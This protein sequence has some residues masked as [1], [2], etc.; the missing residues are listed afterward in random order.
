MPIF[1]RDST[2]S[3][4]S[5]RSAERHDQA[6]GI[7]GLF[8]NRSSHSSYSSVAASSTSGGKHHS[9][10]HRT[11]EDPSIQAAREQVYRA[12]HAERE[13]D[14]ALTASRQAVKEAKDHVKRLEHEAAEE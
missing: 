9:L 12:E 5:A 3:S 7:H 8:G 2:A 1:H 4:S 6:H 14:K 13:A 11:R 10:L